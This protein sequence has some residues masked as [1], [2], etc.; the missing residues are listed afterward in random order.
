M[1]RWLP[2]IFV[3]FTYVA[4]TLAGD[5]H[6]EAERQAKIVAPYCT[7]S[8]IAL[9]HVDLKRLDLRALKEMLVHDA[10]FD[11]TDFADLEASVGSLVSDLLKAGARDVYAIFDLADIPDSP[12]LI[13]PLESGADGSAIVRLLSPGKPAVHSYG[14]VSSFWAPQWEVAEKLDKVVFS[15]S[16]AALARLRKEKP[17]PRAE[18]ADAFA[19][20]GDTAHQALFFPG[21]DAR[22][23]FE[24]LVPTLPQALSGGRSTVLTRGL[25]WAAL[26]A[27]GPPEARLQLVVQASDEAAAK[28]LH[29]LIEKG[30]QAGIRHG[31]GHE[32]MRPF[33]PTFVLLADLLTPA[34]SGDRLTLTFDAENGGVAKFCAA[35]IPLANVVTRSNSTASKLHQIGMALMNY[36]SANAHLPAVASFDKQGKPLLSWRVHILPY[37][38]QTSLYNEFHLDEPWDSEH[39]KHLI[40]RMPAVFRSPNMKASSTGK[41]TFLAP[42]GESL[43]FEGGPEGT[44]ISDITDGA[45]NT[46]FLVEVD[47][48]HGVIWTK[49]DDLRVEEKNPATGLRSVVGRFPVL[50]VDCSSHALPEAID[51]KTLWALFTKNGGEIIGGF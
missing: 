9:A 21:R 22:R 16:R 10:K 45:S 28:A 35:L 39:N 40:E 3:S 19:A 43:M 5:P 29:A 33:I 13:V 50:F 42:V 46:I 24:E 25:S 34:V 4:T 20:A 41:T 11:P 27:S 12:F 7:A 31:A 48:D 51:R 49:P 14:G 17:Q 1:N 23:V 36:E 30:Y 2:T 37:L 26:G 44:K 6:P 47:D 38:E 18:I 15:G 32:S 8:T